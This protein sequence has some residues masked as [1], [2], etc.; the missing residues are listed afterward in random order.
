MA[1]VRPTESLDT[2]MSEIALKKAARIPLSPE[3]DFE[4][5]LVMMLLADRADDTGRYISTDDEK[6]H[7]EI[8]AEMR[9][10]RKRL[11]GDFVIEPGADAFR[12][13]RVVNALEDAIPRRA[14]T[15]Q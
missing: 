10:I 15:V 6:M 4:S 11:N 13:T 2:R 7:S 14:P 12:V 3:M 1:E 8:A 9:A 5:K